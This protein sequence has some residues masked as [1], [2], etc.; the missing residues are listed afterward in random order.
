MELTVRINP[1][2]KILSLSGSFTNTTAAAARQ[3]LDEATAQPP[4]YVVVDLA[5]VRFLDSTALS[6]LVYAM[7]RARAQGGDL[8]LCR[9]QQ[10]VRMIFEMT[11]LDHIFEMFSEQDDAVQAFLLRAQPMP[12]SSEK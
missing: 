5:D 11:R 6:T 10:P 1:P 9:L 2:V 4:A 7:K 12:D 3:W 8:R